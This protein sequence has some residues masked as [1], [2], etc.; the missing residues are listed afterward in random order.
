MSI[1]TINQTIGRDASAFRAEA[2]D[3]MTRLR[4]ALRGL[5]A[6]IPGRQSINSAKEL[7]NA[8]GINYKLAWQ[9][10]RVATASRP[11]EAAC[12]VPGTTTLDGLFDRVAE[13]S[14]VPPDRVESARGAASEF[15]RL[16]LTHA[17][18]R[19]TFDS[20]ASGLAN[21]AG[22]RGDHSHRKAAYRANSHI[23]GIQLRAR[24][25]CIMI[26][27][28]RDDEDR[29]DL[30]MLRGVVGLIQL[31]RGRPF[32]VS[33]AM[34]LDSRHVADRSPDIERLDLGDPIEG[35]NLLRDYCSQPT[36]VIRNRMTDGGRLVTEIINQ[37]VGAASAFTGF[38][39]DVFRNN[40]VRRCD[41]DNTQLVLGSMVKYPTEV[42]VIDILVKRG[43]YGEGPLAFRS[44]C[45][46]LVA[47]AE[48][49][50]SADDVLFRDDGV[51]YCGAGPR[52]LHASEYP[53]YASMIGDVMGRLGWDGDAFDAYRHRQMY[54]VMPSAVVTTLD[55]P[56][57][58]AG[59]A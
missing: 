4:T 13:L 55:L 22:E 24:M 50:E 38:F 9:V 28:S 8:L 57:V 21:D 19:A 18:D 14:G 26:Q 37:D 29:V 39:C 53:R 32:V 27:P 51:E 56:R 20:L 34:H 5:I 15:E 35:I 58:I 36:P 49:H 33:S 17:G 16:V 52:V 30:V 46:S 44:E 10:H 25:S 45:R 47:T 59:L 40:D 42:N 54:P 6:S 12:H 2:Q 11:L 48:P 23:W 1:E 41:A 7:Q 43:T 3:V 31:R